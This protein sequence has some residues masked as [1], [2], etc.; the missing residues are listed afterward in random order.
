M[1]KQDRDFYA[2]LAPY[3][4]DEERARFRGLSGVRIAQALG[5]EL[6]AS[7]SERVRDDTAFRSELIADMRRAAWWLRNARWSGRPRPQPQAAL[8]YEGLQLLTEAGALVDDV[9][10]FAHC[11]LSGCGCPKCDLADGSRFSYLPVRWRELLS[12]AMQTAIDPSR[13]RTR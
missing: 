13:G 5:P 9:L 2:F 4:T 8:F 7:L 10:A 6:C 12:D 1:R 3:L 11:T